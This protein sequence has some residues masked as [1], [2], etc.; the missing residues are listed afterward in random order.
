VTASATSVWGNSKDY[1]ASNVLDEIPDGEMYDNTYWAPA[2]GET[3]GS[4]EI[5]FNGVETFDVV[6]IE[7]YIQK[8]QTISSFSVEYKTVSGLWEEYGSGS[9][10]SSKRLIRGEAVQ[11]RAIRINIESANSTPMITNV[12]VYK[13]SE[14]FAEETSVTLPD[15][16]ISIPITDF[17]L[18]GTW[19][20][21]N[22]NTSAWSNAS[23]SG[24]ASF[25]FTGTKAWIKGT[26]DPNH[27]KMDVYIDGEKVDTADTYSTQ[28]KL[29][30]LLYTTPELEYG[31]HTVKLVCVENAIGMSEALYTDGSGIFEMK[32]AEYQI[33]EGGTVDVEIVRTC[34]SK[35]EV[36]VSY[37]TPSAGAEQGVNYKFLDDSVTFADGETSK[38]ITLTSLENDRT[39]DGMDFYFT[40]MSAEGASLGIN[41]YSRIVIKAKEHKVEETTTPETTTPET[42][43]PETTATETPATETPVAETPTTEAELAQGATK[44]AGIYTY[45]V[46]DAKKHTVEVVKVNAKGKK[47]KS[48]KIY[49]TVKLGS[50]VYK[51][52]SVGASL[53]KG[54]TKV[55]SVIIGKNVTSIG[56]KAFYGCKNLKKITVKSKV[57][58]KTGANAFKGT[59]KKLTIK[60]PKAKLKAYKK[61]LAK[62]GQSKA[63]KIQ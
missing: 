15:N 55:T 35:G 34:G 10:I 44:E 59:S 41:D 11:A 50:T 61:V 29:D 58:T 43:A 36:T 33:D 9:T 4:I 40:L 39:N 1:A 31:T 25:T 14:G 49:N 63:A 62:K 37:A 60:V 16:L 21:E 5:D 47:L 18:E 2:E 7:E 26:I 53:F 17:T 8:G 24:V 19:T 51:V 22:N 42:T 20:F 56:K 46:T 3:T 6:S 45:K 27:G 30:Q 52:T 28:R 48:V 13:A 23:K 54:N 57:L 12:G 38:T 32:E